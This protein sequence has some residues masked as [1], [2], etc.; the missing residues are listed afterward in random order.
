MEKIAVYVRVSDH[1]ESACSAVAQS[2]KIEKYCK[3]HGYQACVSALTVGTYEEAFP[4][5]QNLLHRA[6]EKGIAKVIMTSLDQIIGPNDDLE[7]LNA[8]TNK[9]GITI[10]TLEGESSH[11]Y[12]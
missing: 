12:S 4:A 1:Y 9:S 6:A 7:T 10:E 3:S 11:D 5:F 2:M 8:S